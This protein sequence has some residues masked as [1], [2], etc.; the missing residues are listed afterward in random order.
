M[1][2]D[3]LTPE[4]VEALLA[5]LPQPAQYVGLEHNARRADPAEAEVR[6]C[7]AFPDAYTIGISHLGTGVLYHRL[8]DLPW[9][10]ADRSYCPEP[11]AEAIF[12]EQS[13]PLFGWESRLPLGRF[14][15]VGFSLGYELCVTNVLT[16]LDLAGIPLRAADRDASHPLI[17]GGDA[18]ADTPEPLAEFFDLFLPGDGEEP[19]TALAELLR[20]SPRHTAPRRELLLRIARGVPSA[21]VPQLYE[22]DD[23]GRG[24]PDLPATI[25]HACLGDLSSS[26]AEARPLVPITEAVHERVV[27]EIM[28]GCPN[29]C[30]FCQAGHVR[31]PIRRRSVEEIVAAARAGIDNTGFAEVSLLSLSSSDFGQLDELIERLN[32]EFEGEHVSISLPS[33]RADKQLQLLPKLTGAVRPS[34]LTIAAEAG[35]DRLRR[36]IHKQITEADMLAGVA[37]AWPVGIK[38]VKVYFMAGLPGETWEDIDAII[39]LCRR[40]S[41]T[42]REYDGHR[43]AITASV[44]W[45]VPKPHTPM[46]WE[47]MRDIAYFFDVRSRL[48]DR[49]RRSPVNLKFHRIER[50]VLECL[51]ARGDRRVSRAILAAWQGGARMDSWNE[52]WNWELWEAALAKAGLDLDAIVHSPIPTGRALPWEHIATHFDTADLLQ[53][54]RA[55]LDVLD[56]VG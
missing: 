26:P 54:R 7:L 19:L 45:F 36:A 35:T 17:V 53:R 50:S 56:E 23:A 30:R 2:N 3:Q 48:L 39:D 24:Q 14:D 52:H 44:S 34:G 40:L 13:V 31:Q 37:S 51:I 32:A 43:G 20:E 47:P 33:L 41:D 28:R 18:L 6:L 16:M 12:R 8:N 1:S 25:D 21:Y 49:A 46:Q 22:P 55:M 29:L 42:R 4:P 5:R 15:V 9:C 11:A 38:S 27:I 10:A